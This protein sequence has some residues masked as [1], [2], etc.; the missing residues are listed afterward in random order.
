MRERWECADVEP[1]ALADAVRETEAFVVRRGRGTAFTGVSTDSRSIR[2]GDLFVALRGE[3]FDGH[4]FVAKAVEAGAAG[5]VV[6]TDEDAVT[7]P[8]AACLR[9]RSTRDALLALAAFARTRLQAATSVVGITGSVGKST[10]KELLRAILEASAPGAVVASEKSFNNDVG[11]P[12]TIF[13]ADRRTRHLVLELGT[14]SPGEIERLA[15]IGRPTIGVVTRVAEAHLAGLGSIEAVAREKGALARSLPASGVA[16]LNADDPRV[17]A[18]AGETPARVRT[19]GFSEGADV[20]AVRSK[21]DGD[22]TRFGLRIDGRDAGDGVLALPGLHNV[23][24]ALAA[25]AAASACGVAPEAAL[26]ALAVARGSLPMRLE[27][28]EHAGVRVV[29]DAYNANPASVEAALDWLASLECEGRKFVV[30]GEMNELGEASAELHRRVGRR[31][32][33][34]GVDGL[35]TVGVLAARTGEAAVAAGMPFSSVDALESPASVARLLE[36]KLEPGDVVFVKGSRAAALERVVQDLAARLESR[37]L[38]SRL[39]D[40]AARP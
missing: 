2:P 30:L 7:L 3:T 26:D 37:P 11:L 17:A 5:V 20:R 22:G 36:P 31:V 8:G 16:I 24:N 1:L 28:R 9:V 29:N 13:R 33:A 14:S 38:A 39:M 25:I 27:I 34:S 23:S 12:L 6:E 18:M 19:F 4:A 10:T 40:G 21:P 32:P 35:I 15:A